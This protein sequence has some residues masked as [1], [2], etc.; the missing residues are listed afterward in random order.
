M[1]TPTLE[2]ERLILRKFTEDDLGAL[3]KI[4]S[5]EEVNKFLPWFPLQTMEE[6][7]AFYHKQLESRYNQKCLYNYG[8]CFKNY[9]PVR[10]KLRSAAAH[11]AKFAKPAVNRS[12]TGGKFI[13]LWVKPRGLRTAKAQPLFPGRS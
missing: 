4:Y 13:M 12:R 2:T 10:S 5:D 11:H 1:N 8:I 3:Y 7:R 9:K 6:A